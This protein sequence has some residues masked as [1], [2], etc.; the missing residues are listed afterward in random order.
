[1]GI[2]VAFFM[3]ETVPSGTVLHGRYR[4]E[5]VLGSGGFGHV[6][7]AVEMMSKQQCAVKEYL[8]TGTN[9]QEQL[10]HEATVLSHLHHSH[11]PSFLDAFIESGRYYVVLSYIEGNDLTDLIR[12]VRHR[13]EIV[14]VTK[15][16]HWLLEICDAVTFLHSQQPHVIHR[17][18]K[19]DNIRIT[20]TE[21][22]VLVDLGNAKAAADGSRTLIFIR[23][24]GTPGYA[25]PEQYPGGSGTDTRSDIYA[26]GGT[27]YF[28]LTTR[29]PLSVSARHQAM[30]Q[31][32]PSLPSL[33]EHLT[34]NPPEESPEAKDARQFKLGITKP[35]KPALR[36]SHH[37]A[38]LGLL[39]PRAIQQLNSIIQKAMALK[40]QDRYQFVAD[41]AHDL[42]QIMAL[43]TPPKPPILPPS[44][45]LDPHSTQPDLPELYDA[46]QMAKDHTNQNAGESPATQPM[47]SSNIATT[48]CS[49]CS[50][51]LASR[52]RFCPRCG[53]ALGDQPAHVPPKQQTAQDSV[54]T[55]IE[56]E[57]THIIAPQTVQAALAAYQAE[58]GAQLQTP[59]ANTLPTTPPNGSLSS[60][61]RKPFMQ[62]V[63][64]P[65]PQKQPSPQQQTFSNHPS[66]LTPT[67]QPTPHTPPL[68][69]D[70]QLPLTGLLQ[71]SRWLI[72]T[73]IVFALLFILLLFFILKR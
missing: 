64:A 46:L 5:R 22:A 49:Q 59:T 71:N 10:K 2:H 23:H 26:L 31:G 43:L 27:L 53:F 70:R 55:A 39:P 65:Q 47:L 19:P 63:H 67:Q 11:L 38:Q 72:L 48:T 30:Q 24:Q 12:I 16:L 56:K 45:P 62:D 4:I 32:K 41:F 57:K 28:A 15:I 17:D 13:N 42:R 6:Y 7:L 73:S 21:T 60:S 3:I 29:E 68:S 14:P 1:M 40:P 8:V 44:K 61:Q 52:A 18:I 34:N 50:T 58:Q 9:G 69:T 20:T 25:P 66:P 54:P 51:T 37:I 35:S 33:Q 36:H